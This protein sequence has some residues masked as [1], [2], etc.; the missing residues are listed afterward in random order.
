MRGKGKGSYRR[1]PFRYFPNFIELV[2]F[3]LLFKA[4]QKVVSSKRDFEEISRLVRAE[5]DRFD[6]EKVEDFKSSVEDFLESMVE[7]QK[8]VG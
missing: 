7:N 2:W 3:I 4:E 6:K 5:L 8:E 1:G